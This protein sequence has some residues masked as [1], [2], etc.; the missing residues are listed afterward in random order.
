MKIVTANEMKEIDRIAIDRYGIPGLVLMERAGLSVASK[1]REFYSL[2]KIVVLCGGGNNGGDGIVTAR[3]LHNWG[4]RVKILMFTKKEHLSHDCKTQLKIA[5][6]MNISIEFRESLYKE[7]IH[8]GVIVDAIFGT[9]L[10]K[11][12]T[13]KLAKVF[14]FL[15]GSDSPVVSIDIPSGISADTGEIFGEA[16]KADYTITFGMP[17]RGH[18]LYPGAEYTGRLFIEDIG[19]PATL[20]TSDKIRVNIIDRETASELIPPRPLHSHKGD[21]GHVL[22]LA[23]SIGKTGA[24]IMCTKAAMR[25]GAGLVTIAVPNSLM[26]VFQSK[27]TEE[28]TLPLPDSGTGMLSKKALESI[29]AFI[30]NV[31]VIAVGPGI[32]VSEDTE[33]IVHEL[34][35]NSTVP[36]IIDAD[37]INSLC[38]NKKAEPYHILKRAK[39]PVVLTPHPGEMAR[40]IQ[41]SE[42]LKNKIE[43]DK[44]NT[45]I[46][47]SKKS[48]AYLV[49][50]GMPTIIAE[51]EGR[52]FVNTTGNPGMATAGTGDILTGIIAALTG[53]GLSPLDASI[54]GV[55]LHGLSGDIAAKQTG[56]HSL[57]ATDI[58]DFLPYAFIELNKREKDANASDF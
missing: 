11:P 32:G 2:G 38:K 20:L 17:K 50:K 31:D 5:E 37:G 13:E 33:K 49:F 57:V 55:Y 54:L 4:Y 44:I 19:F 9:G 29:L 58:I 45:A 16:I 43:K 28:M 53:Q 22:V 51:P 21:Y 8:G 14:S 47:F 39:A 12:V 48:G 7:D 35:Q 41:R 10:S 24:A 1:I 46:S 36:L 6:K 30:P 3:N 52:A 26:D 27:V 56:E 23:G 18:Y 34:I 25:S 15:N 40:L 42:E